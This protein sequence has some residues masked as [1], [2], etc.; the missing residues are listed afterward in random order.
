MRNIVE[1]LD[2][3]RALVDEK[4]L[5]K[6]KV[7]G[8][9]GQNPLTKFLFFRLVLPFVGFG[10]GAGLPVRARRPARAA[11]SDPA[12]RLHRRRLCRLLRAQSLRQQPR[13]Q[14]QAVDPDGL[15]GRARPDADL[16]GIGHVDRGGDAQGRRRDRR[17]VG[18]ISPKNSCSPMP[19]FPISRSASRPT[20][21]SPAAPAWNRSS[22]SRRR[23]SRPSATARRSPRRCAC[24]PPKAATCA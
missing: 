2:L 17:P 14:A 9:R 15:A 21:T 20:K 4:T 6:L 1:R 24:W 10:A 11:A 18:R 8:F 19:S 16:R 12:L 7:A 3:R 13:L 23:W 5:N 22:R